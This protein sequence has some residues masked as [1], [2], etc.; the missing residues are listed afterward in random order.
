M[1]KA[2]KIEWMYKETYGQ[3]C[4]GESFE[5]EYD[6]MGEEIVVKVIGDGLQDEKT[7]EELM[8][9]YLTKDLD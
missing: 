8:F 5:F 9:D 3:L 1:S 4:L 6:N 7:I 2:D